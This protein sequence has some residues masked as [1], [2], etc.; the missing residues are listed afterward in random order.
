MS[1]ISQR[2]ITNEVLSLL[3]KDDGQITYT[4]YFKVWNMPD[5]FNSIGFLGNCAGITIAFDSN[6]NRL[7]FG[8]YE[9]R[10]GFWNNLKLLLW[11]RRRQAERSREHQRK[12]STGMQRLL[13]SAKKGLTNGTVVNAGEG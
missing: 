8:G 11:S 2:K 9:L 13:L 3:K 12:Q 5:W 4:C 6:Y 1:N 10:L 7:I